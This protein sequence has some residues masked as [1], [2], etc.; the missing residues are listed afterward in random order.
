[1]MGEFDDGGIGACNLEAVLK[2]E[3]VQSI[4]P[5]NPPKS[6]YKNNKNQFTNMKHIKFRSAVLLIALFA[7]SKLSGQNV[8]FDK[9]VR[10]GDLTLFG[11]TFPRA[12]FW[13]A[14]IYVLVASVIAFWIG[15]TSIRLAFDNEK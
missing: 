2:T 10:A 3:L 15:R 6:G 9:A 1:M 14:F 12:V 13:T 4:T 7:F 11:V 8:I 5:P